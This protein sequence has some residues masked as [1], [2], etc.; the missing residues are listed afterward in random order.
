M[1]IEVTSK[2]QFFPSLFI[3]L[4]LLV[5]IHDLLEGKELGDMVAKGKEV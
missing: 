1:C 2:L 3:E 4:F 5:V